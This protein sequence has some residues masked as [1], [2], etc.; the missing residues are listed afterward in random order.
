MTSKGSVYLARYDLSVLVKGKKTPNIL[1]VRHN[2]LEG[3]HSISRVGTGVCAIDNLF[4]SAPICKP[5]IFSDLLHVYIE[6]FLQQISYF[7]WTLP[8]IIYLKSTPPVEIEW[9]PSYA[10]SPRQL[11]LKQ[12]SG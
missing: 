6:D 12:R 5:L 10:G 4:I 9:W 3:H 7:T 8:K 11:F 2:D 1:Q